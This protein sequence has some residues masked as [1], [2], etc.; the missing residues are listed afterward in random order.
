MIP[1]SIAM[2]TLNV[3]Q[4]L[5]R[6]LESVREFDD[7]VIFDGNS[8][9]ATAAIA[10]EFGAR[11]FSQSPGGPANF[12]LSD[13]GAEKQKAVDASQHDWVFILDADEWMSPAL[14]AQIRTLVAGPPL[15]GT[16][17]RRLVLEDREI[18]HAFFYPDRYPRFFHKSTGAH[19]EPGKVLHEKIRF[20]QDARVIALTS[21]IFHRWP[22]YRDCLEKDRHN[23]ALALDAVRKRPFGI[24]HWFK[25]VIVHDAFVLGKVMVKMILISLAHPG[26]DTLA[27]KWNWRV[28]RAELIQG[29]KT[30]RI[31]F[32]AKWYGKT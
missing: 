3:G 25:W 28:I 13:F 2:I 22:S 24:W 32:R 29:Y 18:R 21:P 17:P 31:I 1:C 20:N 8:T 26:R 16:V 27:W 6:A 11:V 19:F 12:R 9:D 30:T 7:V 23:I 4:T 15:V 5:R 14:V 10:G